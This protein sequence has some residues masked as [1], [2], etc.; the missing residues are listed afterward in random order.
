VRKSGKKAVDKELLTYGIQSVR[1]VSY[2]S[3]EPK[4]QDTFE[5]EFNVKMLFGVSADL[6]VIMI[7]PNISGFANDTK[8]VVFNLISEFAFNVEQLDAY[9]DGDLVTPPPEFMALLINI[10]L[11]TSRGI[12][13][14][15]NFGSVY[16]EVIM[17]VMDVKELIP[18]DPFRASSSED[19]ASLIGE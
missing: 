13:Y 19:R 5:I 16:S 7:R 6:D 11:G 18:K 17:P 9:K 8:E 15:K 10:A 4:R 12:L 1:I 14:A 2:S 3:H